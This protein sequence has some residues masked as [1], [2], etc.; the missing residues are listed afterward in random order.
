MNLLKFLKKKSGWNDQSEGFTLVEVLIMAP[1]MVV[2]I[3]MMTSFLFNQYG[4]LIEQGSKINLDNEAQVI[5]FS[6]EDDVFFASAFVQSLND[7]LVDAH[8]PSGGWNYNTNPQTLIISTPTATKSHRDPAREPVYI[9][10]VGCDPSVLEENSPLHNNIIYFA[11][12]TN[13]YKRIVSAP[14]GMA[15]CGTSFQKQSCPSA[16]SSTSCPPDRLL[17]DKL[18]SFVVTYIDNNNVTTTDPEQASRIKVV[19][20]L[21]DKAF[22]E[23]ITSSSTITFKKLNE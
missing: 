15:T 8:Q 7:G 14:S 1:I 13:L 20:S 6:M 19:L 21:K 17:T 3:V 22:G 18:Q 2:T 16:Q 11:S 12:G 10:T 5:T 4:Q 9:D 23:D